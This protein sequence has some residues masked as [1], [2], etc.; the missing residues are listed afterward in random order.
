MNTKNQFI[1]FLFIA[2]ST[3]K[4]RNYIIQI[5]MKLFYIFNVRYHP[6]TEVVSLPAQI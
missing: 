2:I 3:F 4:E 1:D 5:F 6:T